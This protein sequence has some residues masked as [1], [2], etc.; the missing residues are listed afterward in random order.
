M[1]GEP[2]SQVIYITIL[3]NLVIEIFKRLLIVLY[4]VDGRRI[5]IDRATAICI[6]L[7]LIPMRRYLHKI[8]REN[9]DG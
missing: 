9:P 2:A 4:N 6:N 5:D 1:V 7:N 3:L 8:H